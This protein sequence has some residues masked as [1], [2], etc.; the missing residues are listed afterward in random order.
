MQWLC[1]SIFFH[2]TSL[3][4]CRCS[5]LCSPCPALSCPR[6]SWLKG[7]YPESRRLAREQET[8]PLLFRKELVNPTRRGSER[9]GA[10]PDVV[11]GTLPG[12]VHV[13][14]FVHQRQPPLQPAGRSGSVP[15]CPGVTFDQESFCHCPQCHPLNTHTQKNPKTEPNFIF[16][17]VLTENC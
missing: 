12:P 8:S 10:A 14:G 2:S 6:S 4:S 16:F 3:A 5:F 1:S 9:V 13:S 7:V 15:G 17:Y 11:A